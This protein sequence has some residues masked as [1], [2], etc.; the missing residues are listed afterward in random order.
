L[1]QDD[2]G[3]DVAEDWVR[4]VSVCEP[5]RDR[6]HETDEIGNGDPLVFCA[7]GEGVRGDG[8]G[9]GEG[10]ELLDVLAGPDVGPSE[11][12]ED[13]GLVIDDGYHHD[14]VHDCADN[15]SHDLDGEGVAGG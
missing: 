15:A 9:D 4:P 13:G 2:G 1:P 7:D 14:P 3:V 12:L 8:P 5:E 10:V 11:A 6:D